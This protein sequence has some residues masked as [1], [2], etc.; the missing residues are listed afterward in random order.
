MNAKRAALGRGLSALLQ[1]AE[2]I[3][4]QSDL[5]IEADRI[6]LIPLDKIKTNP[7]QPRSD[8][9][10]QS[11]QELADSIRKQGI[12]QPVSIRILEDKSFQLI[13]GERRLRACALAGLEKIPAYIRKAD[14]Q[15]M[16]EMALVENIQR[17]DLNAMEVAIS[18]QRLVEE[19]NI[20][21]EELSEKVGKNRTTVTNYI[22]LLKLPF[23]IQIAL[24]DNQ[25]SMGHARALI[26][27]DKA[28][29]Q[30]IILK[31]IIAE[32]LS[33]RQV[34]TLVRNIAATDRKSLL[35]KSS[36]ELKRLAEPL[37]KKLGATVEIKANPKGKGSIIIR[38]T[39]KKEM[40]SLLSKL[41]DD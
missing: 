30:L 11:L 8:F 36:K 4:L 29:D 34:E 6:A 16:L 7:F 13:S 12:I 19:C 18:F 33:V 41:S 26:N 23:E 20:T 9:E 32:E 35:P 14:D 40:H 10:E 24:R 15:Q 25:I 5:D 2:E 27:L 3:D 21:Q 38:F 1:S 28:E 17:Q 39:G 22:R 37:I 31:K